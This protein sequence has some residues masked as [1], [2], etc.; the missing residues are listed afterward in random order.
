[1]AQLQQWQQDG[2]KHIVC[3]DANIYHKLFGKAL[4]DIN[5]LAMKEV[6]GKFTH[7][8]VGPTFFWGSKPINSVWASS[9]ITISNACIMPAGYSIG[10]H[11]LFII[12]FQ[13]QDI[14][15]LSPQRM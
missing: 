15:G 2:D 3:L 12:N 6:V 8:P 13:A 10:D 1:M 5:G 9:E 7:Q 11:R 4:T 14:M